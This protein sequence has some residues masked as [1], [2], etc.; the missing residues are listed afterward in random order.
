MRDGDRRALGKQ[1]EGTV[2]LNRITRQ[3]R[4]IYI[5]ESSSMHTGI[6]QA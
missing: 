3:K 5:E 1:I 6:E 4:L 2:E